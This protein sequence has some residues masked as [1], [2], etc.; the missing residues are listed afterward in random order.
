MKEDKFALKASSY[1]KEVKHTKSSEAIANKI[2]KN[3]V[4]DKNMHLL[5][6]SSGTGL[7]LEEL[8]SEVA[9]ITAVDI[10]PSMTKILREK[11]TP[12]KIDIKELDL[13]KETLDIE[14][15]GIISSMTMH[16]IEDIEAMFTKFYSMLKRGGFI[17]IAD[18]DTED[19]SFHT[20]NTGVEHFGFN[21][22]EFLK[23]AKEAGFKNCKIEDA[24]T[25]S[26]SYV[27]YGVFLLTA[28][29]N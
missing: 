13:T 22:D 10:S 15:D 2:R 14:V 21:R 25:I 27:D 6:F 11:T 24:T 23:Y 20:L 4:I 7:L 26:K 28:I 1:D 29:K 5:D 3:I 9:K 18:L 19:G 12:C 8:A 16:H 17:A